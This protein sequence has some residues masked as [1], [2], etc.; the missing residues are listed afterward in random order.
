M[1]AFFNRPT[2]TDWATAPIPGVPQWQRHEA[3]RPDTLATVAEAIRRSGVDPREID[4]V[5]CIVRVWNVV[6]GLGENYLRAGGAAEAAAGFPVVARRADFSEDMLWNYFSHH[7]AVGVAAQQRVVE[8]FETGQVADAL[9]QA[10]AD[11]QCRVEL[12]G[13]DRI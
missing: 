6:S 13:K 8:M 2:T 12:G 10:I 4:R 9:A 7:A 1:A 3:A 5:E 11:G